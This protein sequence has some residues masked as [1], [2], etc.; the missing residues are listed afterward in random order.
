MDRKSARKYRELGQLPEEARKPRT[1]RTW[2]DALAEVWPAVAEQLQQEPRLQAKTL[3]D[4]L[5]RTQPGKVA[6]SMRRTFERRVRQWDR[7][8]KRCSSRRRRCP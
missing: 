5:Q 7:R 8:H 6:E 4:W 2:P 3:W 1:W